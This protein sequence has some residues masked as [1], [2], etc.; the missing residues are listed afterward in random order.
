MRCELSP[1][2]DLEVAHHFAHFSNKQY[3]NMFRGI[4]TN[5]FT[6]VFLYIFD[7]LAPFYWICTQH[8][9][10]QAPVNMDYI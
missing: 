5:S 2:F 10:H 1:S 7:Q 4:G 3:N 6:F 9:I 8:R